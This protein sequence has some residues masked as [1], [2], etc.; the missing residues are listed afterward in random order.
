MKQPA[1]RWQGL[2]WATNVHNIAIAI[3]YVLYVWKGNWRSYVQVRRE[4]P[5]PG[6]IPGGP[7]GRPEGFP[8]GA[9]EEKP[10]A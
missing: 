6:G 5:G 8:G 10:E 9:P 1:D 7:E 4:A 3:L 2:F